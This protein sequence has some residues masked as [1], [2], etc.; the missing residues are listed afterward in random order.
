MLVL[1]RICCFICGN[2]PV[3]ICFHAAVEKPAH[4]KFPR[5][6]APEMAALSH[7]T[8]ALVSFR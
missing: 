1:R 8:F 7:V 6:T 2:K 3:S 5:K 4:L